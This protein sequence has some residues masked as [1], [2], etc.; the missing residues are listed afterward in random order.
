LR[1]LAGAAFALPA[2]GSCAGKRKKLEYTMS[3][4]T[5]QQRVLDGMADR[6][7][8][9]EPKLAAMYAMF[10]RLCGAEGLPIRER[11]PT[12]RAWPFLA[13][14]IAVLT[15]RLTRRGRRVRRLVLI[16][17]QV[18]VAVVLL[19]V[20][21]GLSWRSPADCGQPGRQ[22]AVAPTRLWC[23]TPVAAGGMV[24]K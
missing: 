4:S 20:L 10:T 22:R 12:R 8:R 3:L 1:V 9:T 19:S 6:L 5:A 21:V 23:P 15:G 14:F 17:T 24:S 13:A 11:L 2:S 18:S 7:R 16:A